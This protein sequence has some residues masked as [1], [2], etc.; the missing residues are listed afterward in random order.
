LLLLLLLLLLLA[1][2]RN[3]S[4]TVGLTHLKVKLILR[5]FALSEAAECLQW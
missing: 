5:P 2:L 1:L 4:T 3:M